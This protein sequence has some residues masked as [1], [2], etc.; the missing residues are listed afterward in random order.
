M[1][2][3]ATTLVGARLLG[4]GPASRRGSPILAAHRVDGV[5]LVFKT[6]R[7]GWVLELTIEK[8]G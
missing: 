4:R 7:G 5:E 1:V 2:G 6:D 8:T 3:L